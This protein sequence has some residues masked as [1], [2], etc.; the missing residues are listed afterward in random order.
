M[1]RAGRRSPGD[2]PGRSGGDSTLD[3][4]PGA[5]RE[6]GRSRAFSVSDEGTAVYDVPIEVPPGRAGIEPELS[7]RYSGT[8]ANGEVGMGWRLEG[9]SSITR[10]P[11]IQAIDGSTQAVSNTLNDRFCLDG[12]LLEVVQG[13][14]GA[15]GSEYRTVVDSFSKII[16]H[17]DPNALCRSTSLFSAKRSKP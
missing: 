15:A 10:C 2:D 8:R 7:L 14:Y 17:W 12:K 4:D 16:A 5:G 3:A 1:P 9:L 13:T 6:H 11:R